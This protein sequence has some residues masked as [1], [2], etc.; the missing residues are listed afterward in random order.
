MT[1][2]VVLVIAMPTWFFGYVPLVSGPP[3]VR[4]T[5]YCGGNLA[6]LTFQYSGIEQGYLTR[7]DADMAQY[8]TYASVGPRSTYSTS[9]SIHNSDAKNSHE[10]TGVAIAS[11][12][13]LAGTIPSLPVPVL[14][15][16]NVT[17]ALTLRVPGLPGSYGLPSAV[18]DAT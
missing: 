16:A 18:V 2:A 13:S 15:D 3:V 17:L 5:E 6:S 8:C 14:S 4:V 1:A 11:P 12:F 7:L 10:I 9:I